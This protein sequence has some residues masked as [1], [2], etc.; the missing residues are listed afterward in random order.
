MKKLKFI[1]AMAALV[2]LTL[3]FVACGVVIHKEGSC[4]GY[5]LYG[6]ITANYQHA[7][8][9]DMDGN[10]VKEWSVFGFPAKMLPGGSLIA[11]RGF[12][13]EP[14][15]EFLA[16]FGESIELVQLDW[17]GNVV[18]RFDNWDDDGTERIMARQHHDFQ[19]EGNP[20]GYYVPGQE[21]IHEGKI[22]I[23]AHYNKIVPEISD[24]ELRDDVIYEVDWNG[25]LTGFEW[26][27]ADHFDEMG[28]DDRAKMLIYQNPQYNEER[29]YGDWLHI[30]SV[31][32]L[33]E[34]HWWDEGDVRF[35]PE[36]IIWDSRNANIIAIISRETGEIVWRVGP[37][38]SQLTE[39]GRKLGQIIGPHHAHLIPNG[40]PGAGNI[41]IFDNGGAAGYPVR[42]RLYSRVI[43]FDPVTLFIVWEYEYREGS[44]FFPLW[45]PDHMFFS[46]YISSAQRLPNGNTLITEGSTGRIFEVKHDKEIVWE[47]VAPSVGSILNSVY[48]AYRVPPEWV[49]GNP[50][51]YDDWASLY[52][53]TVPN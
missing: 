9:I 53:S 51:G 2:A 44:M 36:N 43:E 15:S 30:N 6:V 24:K 38:Y 27:A 45:G 31:S 37:D 13:R 17:N 41:L 29:G 16:F 35:N 21:F 11:G 40:L 23:L 7:I 34:N 33:G 42:G 32:L 10:I 22:L 46:P 47:Y 25:E 14:G 19:I 50:S 52:I 5:T 28:F 48:R 3:G 20:V 1:I 8:L 49:P 26:H 18:W 4:E 39:E 12:R